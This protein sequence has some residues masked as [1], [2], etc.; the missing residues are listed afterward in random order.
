MWTFEMR[1]AERGMRNQNP[2]SVAATQREREQP[3][4][5]IDGFEEPV[6]TIAV[7]PDGRYLTAATATELATWDWVSC[8]ELDRQFLSGIVGQLA[9]SPNSAWLACVCQRGEFNL[10]EPRDGGRV[11]AFPGR[12][13]GCVAVSPD[14]KTLAATR[15]GR[16]Q[17]VTLETWELPELRPKT[18]FD[19]WSPFTRLAFSRNGEF[20]AGIDANSFELRIAVT[21]GLN[22]RHRIRYVGD[23]F[24]SFSR[25]SQKVVFGWEADLH[26]MDTSNGSILRRVTS[27]ENLMFQDVAFIGTDR[28]FATVDGSSVM[29]MWSTDSWQVVRAY[30]WDAGGLTCITPSAD[31]LAGICGT[32][33]GKL[34][35][36]DVDE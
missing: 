7:S 11:H 34:V 32:K 1:S 23:G 31:G 22:G 16:Q 10:I 35:I 33:S 18:G 26:I 24:F 25:D 21:G 5:V 15:T 12:F 8:E 20:L 27:P 6:R 14:G 2:P 13:S 3:M 19:F 36:F 30:D 9:Y 17:S 29:R 28:Q 4:R